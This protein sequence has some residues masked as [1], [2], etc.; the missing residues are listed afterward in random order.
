M[1][2]MYTAALTDLLEGDLDLLVDD[3]RVILIDAGAYTFSAAHDF[4]DDITAGG[5][6]SNAVA[7]AGKTVTAGVLDATDTVL[8]GT[9]TGVTVEAVVLYKHTGVEATSPLVAYIDGLTGTTNGVDVTVQWDNGA[10]KI[11]KLG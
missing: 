6:E 9:T 10:N 1:S 2:A 7:L 8:T 3:I 11:L 4:L 5:R